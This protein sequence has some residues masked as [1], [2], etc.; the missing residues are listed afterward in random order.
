MVSSYFGKKK[1]LFE[2]VML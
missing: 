1:G 2:D